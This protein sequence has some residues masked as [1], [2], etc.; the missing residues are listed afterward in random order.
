MKEKREYMHPFHDI[1]YGEFTWCLHCECV[2]K[3]KKWVKNNWSCPKMGCN[4][5]PLD[6]FLWSPDNWPKIEHPEYPSDPEP[7]GYYPL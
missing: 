1:V 5:S 4:G 7:G 6:A 3:T 2:H